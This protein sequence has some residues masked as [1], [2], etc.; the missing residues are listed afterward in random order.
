MATAAALVIQSTE[1]P[2]WR[3]HRAMALVNALLWTV[4]GVLLLRHAVG[5]A[6]VMEA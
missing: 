2:Y 6:T 4:I 3:G 1:A 5:F